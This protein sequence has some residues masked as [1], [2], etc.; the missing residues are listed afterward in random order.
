[1]SARCEIRVVDVPSGP[2]I[3]WPITARR[4]PWAGVA[5]ARIS[6]DSTTEHEVVRD[7]LDGLNKNPAVS[8]WGR[9]SDRDRDA[10]ISWFA[11][12]PINHLVVLDAQHLSAD[13]LEIVASSTA[14]TGTTL[15]LCEEQPDEDY[16]N[17]RQQWPTVTATFDQLTGELPEPT[18]DPVV[19]PFPDVVSDGPVTFL[20]ACRDRLDPDAFAVVADRFATTKTVAT[21]WANTTGELDETTVIAWLRD[22]LD[23]CRHVPE[24]LT[25][26][27]ATQVAMLD[28]DGTRWWVQV[29]LP[30]LLATADNA[31]EATAADP[32]TWRDLAAYR[33]P[34]VGAACALVVA[35]AG[36]DDLTPLTLA[37]IDVHG[38][39]VTLADSTRLEVHPMA[40]VYLRA[41]RWHRHLQGASAEDLAFADEGKPLNWRKLGRWVRAPALD[42]GRALTTRSV[43]KV[44]PNAMRWASRYGVSVAKL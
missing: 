11:G 44:R 1:M 2:G 19:E 22:Q 10:L 40:C 8:S 36:I 34:H 7:L 32:Q 18:V 33:D 42:L 31:P 6:P 4:D 41:L 9:D 14:I 23:G 17:S 3:T 27:R 35:G 39:A 29:D 5:V 26:V 13:T 15:W 21:T 16:L 24:M 38:T 20:A 28:L 12:Y 30:R 43:G 37:Q 25:V